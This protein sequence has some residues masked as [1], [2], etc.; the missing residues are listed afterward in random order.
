MARIKIEWLTDNHRCE[1]CGTSWSDGA[2]VF[3]DGK[4]AIELLP[5]A[6]C[7]GGEH[8]EQH[9]VYARVF[10]HLGHTLDDPD[11]G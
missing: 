2:R 9:E 10:Q 6:H 8:Y 5:V 4:P 7:F 3:I 11:N 1:T